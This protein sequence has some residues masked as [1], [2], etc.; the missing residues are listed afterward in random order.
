IHHAWEARTRH[1]EL[2]ELR[3]DL[4]P[5]TFVQQ[6]GGADVAG[7]ELIGEAAERQLVVRFLSSV[8]D[9][10]TLQLVLFSPQRVG[11]PGGTVSIPSAAPRN[12][13][14]E[15]GVLG[16]F[17]PPHL[18]LRMGAVAGVQQTDVDS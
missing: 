7:W 6:V 14:R 3:F 15:S 16:V 18:R 8:T 9:S 2:K 1:G 17:A 12:V 10:S 13:T 4:P 11:E 5:E